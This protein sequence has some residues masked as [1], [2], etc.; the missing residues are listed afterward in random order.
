MRAKLVY[1]WN[2]AEEVAMFGLKFV[3]K[4]SVKTIQRRES[5]KQAERTAAQ[6]IKDLFS[7][8]D[9]IRRFLRI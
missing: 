6:K 3:V 1:V 2:L 4:K 9:L 8:Y 5:I 7:K